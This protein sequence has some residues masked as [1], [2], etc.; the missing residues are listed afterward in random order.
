MGSRDRPGLVQVLYG[1]LVLLLGV[2][3][4][5]WGEVAAL[6][7]C[8]IDLLPR[9]VE[10]HRNAVT[11][12]RQRS[13]G[14]LMSGNNRTVVLQA[15]VVDAF[16][17]T[18]HGKGRDELLWPSQTGG[19]LVPP[20]ARRP[21]HQRDRPSYQA[22]PRPDYTLG[23]QPR[24]ADRSTPAGSTDTMS[25]GGPGRFCQD[26]A[27]APQVVPAQIISLGSRAAW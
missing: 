20:A 5:R 16:V 17:A 4:L 14:T 1:S 9:H 22:L 3:G 8:D 2:G 21:P 12:G 7:V 18:A 13:I 19:Y 24:Q 23:H 15:L 25:E 27:A 11:V 26:R 10:L 6:R